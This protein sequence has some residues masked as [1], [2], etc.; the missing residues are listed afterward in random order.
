MPWRRGPARRSSGTS[1]RNRLQTVEE[2]DT[3]V[4]TIRGFIAND[5]ER[6]RQGERI[7]TGFVESTLNPEAKAQLEELSWSW[8]FP[9]PPLQEPVTE[10]GH[11]DPWSPW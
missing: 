1:A 3:F 4:E 7:R 10:D 9:W 6:Y 5:G 11:R 2:L 8:P